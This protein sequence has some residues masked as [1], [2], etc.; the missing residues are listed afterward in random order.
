MVKAMIDIDEHANRVL[1]VVK[2]M[3]DLP[4]KSHAIN[5][6]ATM[7]EEEIL[8]PEFSPAYAEKLV[9]IIKEGKYSNPMTLEQFKKQLGIKG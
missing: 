7:Y 5:L 1:N 4:D 9:K 3:Y 8:E 6:M 2:A